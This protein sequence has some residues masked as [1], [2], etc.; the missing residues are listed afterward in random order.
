[1]GKKGQAPPGFSL[2]LSGAKV[3]DEAIVDYLREYR[4]DP[5]LK[6]EGGSKALSKYLM[7]DYQ[8]IVNHKKV[9]RLCRVHG[10]ALKK[11]GKK[12]SK[13]GQMAKNHQVTRPNQVWEFDIKYGYLNGEK[14]FFFFLAFIDVFTRK[15][16]GWHLGYNCKAEQLSATLKLALESEKELDEAGLIIRSY[17]GPQMRAKLFRDYVNELPAEHEFIPVRTPNKNAHIESFFSIYDRHLQEQYFW[18]LKDAY[19]WTMEFVDFY[20]N[21]RIHGSL[22]MSPVEF[23]AKKELHDGEKFMQAI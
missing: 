10:L 8:L 5:F 16:K 21:D 1:M 19:R 4:Q 22:G 2:N 17:N 3:S 7:R 13:F 9:A 20:N 15:I 11:R 12:K 14:K 23:D 6:V 18:T